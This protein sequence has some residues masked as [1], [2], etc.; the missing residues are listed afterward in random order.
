MKNNSDDRFIRAGMES[1]TSNFKAAPPSSTQAGSRCQT[2]CRHGPPFH[3]AISQL[4][5][6]VVGYLFLGCKCMQTISL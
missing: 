3:L 6:T 1:R 5:K 2:W 4:D